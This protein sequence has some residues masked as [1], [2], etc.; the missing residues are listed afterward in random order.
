MTI[1]LRMVPRTPKSSLQKHWISVRFYEMGD[2]FK[3]VLLAKVDG[4][5]NICLFRQLVS[6]TLDIDKAPDPIRGKLF[7]IRFVPFYAILN[8]VPNI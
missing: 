2:R 1:G 4:K 7:V 6:Y 8:W 5:E 3:L